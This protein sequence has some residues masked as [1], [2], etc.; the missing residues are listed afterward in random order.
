MAGIDQVLGIIVAITVLIIIVATIGFLIYWLFQPK[1][2]IP[3]GQQ[4]EVDGDC[5]NNAC[6]RETAADDALKIC[7]PSGRSD[8]FAGFDYCAAM[9]NGSVCWSDAQCA[10]GYCKDN[11]GGLQKGICSGRLEPNSSCDVNAECL[12]QACGRETAADGA[13]K[14]CCPSGSITNYGGFDYCTQMPVGSVCWS[15]FMCA[16]GVCQGNLGGLQKGVCQAQDL[17]PGEICES[18]SDCTN[19]A[20]GRGTAANGA[21]KICCPSG[22][23]T[24]YGGFDYCTQML[25]GSVCWSDAMCASNFCRGNLGGL[26]RGICD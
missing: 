4:C 23:I 19:N 25:S 6:G 5:I 11:Q 9:P 20:C 22:N 3:V 2:N 8:R 12:N 17:S 7:C 16:S 14:I 26:Q 10:A 15:D 13:R 21:Q 1:R 18:N 24:T